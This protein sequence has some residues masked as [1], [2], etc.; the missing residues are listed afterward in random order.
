MW[1]KGIGRK[2]CAFVLAF[3][4][5]LPSLDGGQMTVQ[6]EQ[7]NRY[8]V[9]EYVEGKAVDE[10]FDL[11][12]EKSNGEKCAD[13]QTA[14]LEIGDTLT[15]SL[16]VKNN[17]GTDEEEATEYVKEIRG[18]LEYDHSVFKE[19]TNADIEPNIEKMSGYTFCNNAVIET[20]ESNGKY[21]TYT[22]NTSS[23]KNIESDGISLL[24]MNS[25]IGSKYYGI[26]IKDYTNSA[27]KPVA[28]FNFEVKSAVNKNTT[29]TFK[30]IRVTQLYNVDAKTQTG[31]YVTDKSYQKI[32]VPE[33][34]PLE[35]TNKY[36]DQTRIFSMYVPK[37]VECYN[38]NEGIFSIP[39]QVKEE[40]S[41][42]TKYK[43]VYNS[44]QLT[45][46]YDANILTFKD[47]E[48]SLSSKANYYTTLQIKSHKQANGEGTVVMSVVS[49][50][51]MN[52]FG[53][54][55]YLAFA[56][57]KVSDDEMTEKDNTTGTACKNYP[58]AIKVRLDDVA[59]ASPTYMT[60]KITSSGGETDTKTTS[61]DPSTPT[62]DISIPLQVDKMPEITF[63]DV[64]GDGKVTL[65][66]VTYILQSYNGARDL[67]A[68]ETKNADVDGS[69]YVTLADGLYILK[70]INSGGTSWAN[71]T[72]SVSNTTANKTDDKTNNDV[73]VKVTF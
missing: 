68:E 71:I 44:V 21:Y 52:V 49:A 54:F 13:G 36:T 37:K 73:N 55:I 51:D 47:D 6:A 17:L 12:V 40:K 18:D 38:T 63:G 69:G 57:N 31:G 66:D 70:Y 1:T 9:D 28:R 60:Y 41:D 48:T 65:L 39:L 30:N 34:V 72:D 7:T 53:D 42:S 10:L 62:K 14:S 46:T 43:N 59:N 22:D 2:L 27:E 24:Y 56:F 8:N 23:N 61:I 32:I 5:V 26:N 50:V 45:V 58:N 35:L 29:I 4:M 16:Y 25:D 15:I 67:T 19:L 64:N 3:A 11:K 33:E 20:I